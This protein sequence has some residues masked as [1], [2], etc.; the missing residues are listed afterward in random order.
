[1]DFTLKKYY[2]LLQ[3]IKQNG[4]DFQTFEEFMTKPLA[5]VVVLRHDSDVWPGNDL[6]MALMERSVNVKASYYFRMPETFNTGIIVKIKELEHEIGYHYED[7]AR[8]NG[9]QEAAI[10]NFGNN[11]NE[12]RKIYPVKTVARHGRPLSRWESLDLWK[13]YELGDF[14]LIGEPYLSVDYSSVL[15]LTDTG[16]KWNAGKENI[17]DKVK[18]RFRFNFSSTDD[19]IN[20]FNSGVLPDKIILNVHAARWNDNFGIWFYRFVLQKI[21]NPAKYFLSLIRTNN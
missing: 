7:L 11:L 15:Y 20:G 3:A 2:E 18:S 14:D 1:M 12:I 17:R 21:K 19:L 16:S 5:R 10:K 13:N 8:F 6:A 9:D 4:Y